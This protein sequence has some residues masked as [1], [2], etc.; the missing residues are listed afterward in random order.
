MVLP[1]WATIALLLIEW[2]LRLGLVVRVIMR[3]RPVPT[4]LAWVAILLLTPVFGIVLYLLIGESRLGRRRV[5]RH[6]RIIEDLTHRAA[7]FWHGGREDWTDDCIPYRPIATLATR[8]GLI[9][10]LRGNRLELIG[11]VDVY[12]RRLV[13][14]IDRAE[15]H[16][17]LLTYI[18]QRGEAGRPI[19][20][21][22]LR[23]RKRGVACRVLVDGVGS[24]P[25]LDSEICR[26]LRRADIPVEA[27]MPVNAVRA[28]AARLDL[29]NHRK[30]VVV[31]GRIAYT[32]SHNVT[33]AS[34]KHN[35]RS[36]VGPWIDASV[37]L[38]GPAAQALEVVFL[39]D[40]L[41]ESPRSTAAL[42][43]LLPE[44]EIPDE[45]SV[46][47]VVPSM[48]GRDIN[49]IQE[50]MTAAIYMARE[51]L[52]ITTPYFVPNEA[53]RSALRAACMRGVHLD[54]VFPAVNDSPLVAAASRAA[55]SN[56][57]HSSI[58]LTI[59]FRS[60][61]TGIRRVAGTWQAV[62]P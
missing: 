29:R 57:S 58:S 30:I 44:L 36:G 35:P 10:P 51:E 61:F 20:D 45:G 42:E 5:A 50:A 17:H 3:R 14:D 2:A 6:D 11:D 24:R 47:H 37:R 26:E 19:A 12:R 13:E 7:R 38:V 8:V 21:A 23:A 46:A 40:W 41:L 56:I 55:L 9:A 34:F 4:S 53:T 59:V 49:A 39:H 1:A 31:D 33:D 54:L 52:I 15:S 62:M 22:L 16:V 32:G 25:F 28:L 27:S 18:W 60:L 43:T 48:P